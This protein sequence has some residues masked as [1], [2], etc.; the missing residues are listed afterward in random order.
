MT[1]TI[2]ASPSNGLVQSADGSGILKVQSNGVTTNAL[3]WVNFNGNTSPGTIRASYNVGSVTKNGTGDYTIN[4]STA[5]TDANY[6]ALMNGADTSSGK[7]W[8]LGSS[9]PT[10]SA[11]RVIS[12]G[13]NG[14]SLSDS[15]YC[16]LAV[17][18]N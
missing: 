6:S 4:F 15:T 18:G 9:A 7:V 2:N 17:F 12:F 8:G 10:N 1:T 14:A 16:F 11:I 3:A 5:L 13:Y